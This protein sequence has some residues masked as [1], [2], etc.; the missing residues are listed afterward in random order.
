[1]KVCPA[2]GSELV[3]RP[4]EDAYKFR[5]RKTCGK[6]CANASLWT[7]ARKRKDPVQK[8]IEHNARALAW[9][10]ANAEKVREQKRAWAERNREQVREKSRTYREK[11]P[12]KRRESV[13]AWI[14]NNP[15]RH[16]E[17]RARWARKNYR[18][19]PDDVRN[20]A[21]KRRAN[22]KGPGVSAAQWRAILSRY[23]NRCA[24][25]GAEGKL[26]QDHVVPVSRGGA[27]EP[28]NIVP[29]CKPCNS[30]KCNKL[31][32]E[33]KGRPCQQKSA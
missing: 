6:A 22:T 1:M 32:S 12:E 9:A 21:H 18:L 8:R 19:N 33:W 25:C 3:R 5:K 14:E 13:Y 17:N 2:C 11:N 26:A 20:Q 29:A 16:R 28:S 23:G 10:K 15:E 27:H 31:L 4:D 30:S 24:Y 7:V